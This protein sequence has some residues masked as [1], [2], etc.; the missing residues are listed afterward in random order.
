MKLAT[1]TQNANEVNSELE[2]IDRLSSHLE[3]SGEA[4]TPA[5]MLGLIQTFPEMERSLERSAA[6]KLPREAAPEV[7]VCKRKRGSAWKEIS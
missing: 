7:P 2:F 3:G 5:A 1:L 6:R 4:S